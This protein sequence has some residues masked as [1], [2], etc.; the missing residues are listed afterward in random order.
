MQIFGIAEGFAMQISAKLPTD[1]IMQLARAK[2]RANESWVVLVEVACQDYGVV[3]VDDVVIIYVG[4]WIP[5][6]TCWNRLEGNS[7][8][9]CVEY[10]NDEVGFNVSRYCHSN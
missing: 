2:A 8:R 7:Q 6:R 3:D 9:D 4:V 10:V 1:N 5:V